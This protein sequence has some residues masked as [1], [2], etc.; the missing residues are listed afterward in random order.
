MGLATLT[1][2]A[3]PVT[4]DQ[5]KAHLR[6]TDT[7]DDSTLA[8]YIAAAVEYISKATNT[9][10]V[11]TTYRLTLDR[12]PLIDREITLTRPP[13]QSVQSV[14]FNA[15]DGT[16]FT[17]GPAAY[18]VDT[19]A[20]P[21]RIVLNPG[22]QWPSAFG[23]QAVAIEYTAGYVTVPALLCQAVKFYTGFLFENR[24]AA[25]DR[26]IDVVPLAV[27]SIVNM[28]AFPEAAG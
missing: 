7:A 15:A 6:I 22:Y 12:F 1:T 14:K 5:V 18:T 23:V 8:A 4:L 19:S 20:M 24:E 2:S 26:R 25:T 27:E 21:G 11:T 9:T 16:T 3:S 10:L 17:L 13:L 28:F